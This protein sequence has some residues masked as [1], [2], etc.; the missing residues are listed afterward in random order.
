M[1]RAARQTSVRLTY[2]EGFLWPSS[3]IR[4]RHAV[5]VEALYFEGCL[6][7]AMAG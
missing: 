1:E 2:Q 5:V 7:L 6:P 4:V 3:A